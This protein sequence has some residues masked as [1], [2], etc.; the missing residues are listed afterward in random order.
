MKNSEDTF[1]GFQD[2]FSKLL[3]MFG[4]AWWVEVVTTSPRCTYYFGPFTSSKS[5]KVAQAG[6]VEDLKQEGARGIVAAVKRCKPERL[7][8]CEEVEATSRSL[9]SQVR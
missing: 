2:E 6:Y 3:N 4:L 7:T 1:S 8:I 5:A 9:I